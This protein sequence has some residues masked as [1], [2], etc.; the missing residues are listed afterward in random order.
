M[1]VKVRPQLTKEMKRE[2]EKTLETEGWGIMC[3]YM[4]AIESEYTKLVL[5]PGEPMDADTIAKKEVYKHIIL[6]V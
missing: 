4:E 3:K 6:V 2:V 1:E 5:K